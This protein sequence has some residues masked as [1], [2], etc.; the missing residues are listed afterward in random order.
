MTVPPQGSWPEPEPAT[1]QRADRQ[2]PARRT[3][4]IRL[5]VAVGA[6]IAIGAAAGVV[7][8]NRFDPG[9]AGQPDSLQ[10]MLDSLAQ[11]RAS[12]DPR[13]QRRAADSLD[14]E[15]RAQRMADSS[16]QANDPSAVAVPALL[17]LEEGAARDS[18]EAAGLTTGTVVFQPSTSPLGVVVGTSPAVGMKVRAGTAVNLVLSNGRPPSD[19]ADSHAATDHSSPS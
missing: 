3:W 16:N 15:L 9:R 1:Q 5:G 8:V 12:N 7:A 18:I 6:G 11:R 17:N 14:A 10:L 4:L 19:S 13:A 2:S